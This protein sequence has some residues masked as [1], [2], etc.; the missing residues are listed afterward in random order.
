MKYIIENFISSSDANKLI[1]FFNANDHLCFDDRKEHSKRNIHFSKISDINIKNILIYYANKNIIFIDHYFKTKTMLWQQ[2]RLCRW[3][4]NDE[5][6]MHFDKQAKDCM[7][8]SSLIYLN[9]NYDGGELCFEENSEKK[10]YKMK[11]FSCVIF[12]SHMYY[13]GVKKILNGFRYTIPS[14]YSK[15]Q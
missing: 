13:H 1:K 10:D 12:P 5:M 9:D 8:Y 11:K 6:K 3:R 15:I 2:M 7:D 4:K 14:W